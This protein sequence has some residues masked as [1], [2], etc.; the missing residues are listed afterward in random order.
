MLSLA[1]SL[2]LRLTIFFTM[3]IDR[4]KGVLKI[5]RNKYIS[6][7]I[8]FVIWIA[9]FDRND[10]FTQWDRKQELQK[11]ETSQTFYEQEIATTKKDLLELNSNPA[12]LEKFAREKFYL[13]RPNEEIFIVDDSSSEKSNF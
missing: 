5:L 12:T 9:F 7:M 8:V 4:F 13:K 11:L 2:T 1:V 6:S 10:L 3:F